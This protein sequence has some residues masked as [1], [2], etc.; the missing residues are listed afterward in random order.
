M[1]REVVA[2]E[3]E[4]MRELGFS[5]PEIW[6]ALGYTNSDSWRIALQ[7]YD[8]YGAGR[9]R[10]PK[11]KEHGTWHSAIS[12]QCKCKACSARRRGIYDAANERKRNQRAAARKALGDSA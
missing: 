9:V 1:N 10:G 7:R 2:A 11:R 6:K 12:E 4:S 5:D 8:K 3:T